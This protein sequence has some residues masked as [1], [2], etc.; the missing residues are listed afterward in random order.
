MT[1][2][3]DDGVRDNSKNLRIPGGGRLFG[4]RIKKFIC[5]G[6]GECMIAC[7]HKVLQH[8]ADGVMEVVADDRCVGCLRCVKA[9]IPK[10]IK[11]VPGK[12]VAC[13]VV[14]WR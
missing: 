8:G 12:G 11:I 13:K 2:P 5:T 6:C 14:N 10:A 9:C 1:V 4:V 7:R 3:N